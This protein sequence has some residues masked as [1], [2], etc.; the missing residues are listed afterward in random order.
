MEADVEAVSNH[1]HISLCAATPDL[2]LY[3][4]RFRRIELV[5]YGDHTT[6]LDDCNRIGTFPEPEYLAQWSYNLRFRPVSD[7]EPL[8]GMSVSVSL[9]L[10]FEIPTWF[11]LN[12]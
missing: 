10:K 12:V 5:P 2:S 1:R 7:S 3:F 6:A 9:P 11:Q 8:I 4:G